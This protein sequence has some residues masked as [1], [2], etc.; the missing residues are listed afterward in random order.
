MKLL[1]PVIVLCLS[2][3][4]PSARSQPATHADLSGIEKYVL[5][6]MRKNNVPGISVGIVQDGKVILARGYGVANVELS[7]P[8]TENTVYQIASVTKTFTATAIMMLVEEGKL[9]LD[10]KIT[11]RLPGLPAAWKEVAVRQ[12][13]THTS[14]I[15]SYTSVKDFHKMARKDY[16]RREI[17]ELVKNDALEFAPG[18]SWNYSNTGYFLLG[19]LIEKETGKSYG[20]FM[21]NR[22]FKPLGM[23]QTR[24]NDLHAIIPNRAQ[25]YTWDGKET[26]NGEYVSPTQ[27]FAA[28]MLVSTVSD[29]AKWDAAMNSEKLLKKSSL[30]Q[31]WT[32][33]ALGKG[34]PAKYGFGWQISKVNGHRRLS[35]GGGIPG[36]SSE[37]S[38]FV[39]DKLTVIV[40]SNSD[41][42][43][44]GSLAQGIARRILPSLTVKPLEPIADPDSQTTERL[45]KVVLGGMKGEVDPELF[46]EEARKTVVEG[47]KNEG[48]NQLGPL[49]TLKTFRL[50]EREVLDK[51]MRLR[52]RAEFD[53]ATL[54]LNIQLDERGKIAHFNGRSP[55]E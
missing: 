10:N 4:S 33:A 49:G 28:G 19:L 11:A 21:A 50:L 40:L 54:E 41:H 34:G 52:Y 32:P 37:L 14:G 13:L 39:D 44:A 51:S 42:C 1:I 2:S 3:A 30:D 29:L 47:I 55:D 36:F 8:A 48:K 23:A 18:E 35:H 6:T 16:D 9:K 53:K 7:V 27:P 31:M 38:R 46:T 12:L 24:V 26:R 15:K 17:L 22:I 20:E 45:K 5:S 43:N 25:G